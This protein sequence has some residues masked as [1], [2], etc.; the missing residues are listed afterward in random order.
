[1]N[2]SR[3]AVLTSLGCALALLA[4]PA[5]AAT[6]KAGTAECAGLIDVFRNKPSAAVKDEAISEY[7]PLVKTYWQKGCAPGLYNEQID[8]A[9]RQRIEAVVPQPKAKA[10]ASAKKAS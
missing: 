5:G 10:K 8:P 7:A 1:M 6:K 9:L 4:G 3:L 2:S